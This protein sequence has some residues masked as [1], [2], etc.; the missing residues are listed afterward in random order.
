M[1]NNIYHNKMNWGS[2]LS[3]WI[4]T[5]KP[6]IVCDVSGSVDVKIEKDETC[7]AP[8]DQNKENMINELKE[9]IKDKFVE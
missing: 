2:W 4:W 1:R 8:H 3:S 9:K 5:P 7:V 6:D